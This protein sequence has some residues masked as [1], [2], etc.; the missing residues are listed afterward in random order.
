MPLLE[1]Q[2]LSG[3][4]LAGSTVDNIVRRAWWK[5]D[6]I[7]NYV[8]YELDLEKRF[9]NLETNLEPEEPVIFGEFARYRGFG[10][11]GDTF[12][13]GRPIYLQ[14]HWE[15]L[16]ATDKDYMIYV[17]LRD[18]AGNVAANWDGPVSH[19]QDG[20][21]YSTLL[22][23]PGE[24]IRDERLLQF[25]SETLPPVGDDYSLYIGMYDLATGTRLPVTV[26]GQAAGDGYRIKEHLK[27]VPEQP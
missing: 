20:R 3:L 16:A 22:W 23:E 9:S 10:L 8:V 1:N 13:P 6:G 17:H 21:Y 27:V 25:S 11:G 2:V 26:G 7:F 5:D 15:T 14:L 24:F 4:S 18:T 19:S 12:W